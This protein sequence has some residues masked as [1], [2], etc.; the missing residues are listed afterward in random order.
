MEGRNA[1]HAFL[2]FSN[3]SI[4]HHSLIFIILT[5]QTPIQDSVFI[6]PTHRLPACPAGK[7]YEIEH[8]HSYPK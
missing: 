3:I 1:E 5:T 7:L 6:Y 8:C 2:Q 4:F